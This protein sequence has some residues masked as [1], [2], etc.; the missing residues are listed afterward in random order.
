MYGTGGETLLVALSVLSLVISLVVANANYG[1][2]AR[3]MESSYKK[4]QQIHQV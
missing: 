4:I 3:S 2:R 1:A